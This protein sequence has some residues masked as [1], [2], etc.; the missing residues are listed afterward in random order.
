M[1]IS[2]LNSALNYYEATLTVIEQAGESPSSAVIL[3]VLMARDAVQEA[4]TTV[5]IS[6]RQEEE[7]MLLLQLDSRLKQQAGTIT[8]VVSLA[9]WRASF[10][11]PPNAW[12]WFLE[13]PTH[14][15][16]NLDWLWN[17]CTVAS[18]TG[19]LS[20][21]VDISSRF[22]SGGLNIFGSFAVISQSVLMLLT[23]GGVLTET[24]RRGIEEMLSKFGIKK[25]LWQEVKLGLSVLLLLSLMG[26][27]AFLPQI[28]ACFNHWGLNNYLS[29]KWSTAQSDYKLALALDPDNAEAHYNLGRLY[30]DLDQLNQA[31]TQ[32]QLAAQGDLDAG[33]NALARLSIKNKKYSEAVSL[34]YRGLELVSEE[35]KETKYALQKNLGW[36]HLEQKRY[37]DAKNRLEEAISLDNTESPQASAHCLL[38]QVLEEKDSPKSALTAWENCLR[39]ASQ[40]YPEEYDWIEQAR[41]RVDKQKP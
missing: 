36:A 12:W 3:C 9:D 41:Q 23:T 37:D 32:Y 8:G 26:F 21:V 13:A 6:H 29:G 10:Y 7:L 17:G 30:E 27:R 15:L 1:T 38:A 34:L 18:L 5:E 28:S 24:G 22:I 39:Y 25:Y 20:L 11:P 40:L 33:Y 2:E 14:R 35:D 16:D 4:L 31:K 19:S